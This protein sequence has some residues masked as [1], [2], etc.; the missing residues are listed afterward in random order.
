MAKIKCGDGMRRMKNAEEG[1]KYK[2]NAH[3]YVVDRICHE[4]G[5]RFTSTFLRR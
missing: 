1:N 5:V 3:S 2:D 4:Y